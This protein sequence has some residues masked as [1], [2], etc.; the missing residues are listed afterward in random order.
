MSR[1][2]AI[3]LLIASGAVAEAASPDAPVASFACSGCH[4]ASAVVQTPVPRLEGRNAAE[5]VEQMQAFRD[6]KREST[7]MDRIAKGFTDG[8]IQDIAAYYAKLR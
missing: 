4:P 1:I 5:I 7:V 3:A 2:G 6:G 8:E